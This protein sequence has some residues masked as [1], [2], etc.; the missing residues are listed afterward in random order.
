MNVEHSRVHLME[1]TVMAIDLGFKR[2]YAPGAALRKRR[3]QMYELRS[4][5]LHGSVLMQMDQE[6]YFGWDPPGS[7]LG[8]AFPRALEYHAPRAAKLADEFAGS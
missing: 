3:T 5:I 6:L 2:F 1:S 4:G 8:R 7:K